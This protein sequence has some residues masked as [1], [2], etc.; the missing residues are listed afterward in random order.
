MAERDRARPAPP[1]VGRE[2]ELAACRDLLAGV[3]RRGGA[4][5]LRGAPGIGKSA[6]LHVAR[7]EAE[8]LGFAV[9]AT[10]GL[11]SQADLPYAALQRLLQPL[12]TTAATELPAH[13]HDALRAAFGHTDA[14]VEDVFLVGLAT[15]TL[16]TTAAASRPRLLVVDD[17]PWLDVSTAAVLGFVVRRIEHDPIVV[18]AA[19]RDAAD[20]AAAMDMP[21]QRLAPLDAD[22]ARAVLDERA[23][24]LSAAVRARVLAQA[25]GN[26]LALVELPLALRPEQRSAA[27]PVPELLPLTARLERAFA[28][29]LA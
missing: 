9:L 13:Q 22:A 5:H 23:P 1:L 10:A 8:A 15:L 4:L 28:V 2:P 19:G 27:A 29:R 21:E 26:P 14:A 3:G 25:A 16:L 7:Q 17:A 18:L 12:L 6:L 11:E 20:G 24:R